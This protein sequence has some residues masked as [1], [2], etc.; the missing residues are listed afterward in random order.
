MNFAKAA[1]QTNEL[2]IVGID[3]RNKMHMN[4]TRCSTNAR[5]TLH[6]WGLRILDR[7]GFATYPLLCDLGRSSWTVRDRQTL[8]MYGEI[9]PSLLVVLFLRCD[10][11]HNGTCVRPVR[12]AD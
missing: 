10:S 9:V 6:M 2:S 12:F 5:E 4:R 1:I 11:L 8:H 3:A 7:P